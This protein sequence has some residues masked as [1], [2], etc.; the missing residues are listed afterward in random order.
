MGGGKQ[1]RGERADDQMMM[2]TTDR[3]RMSGCRR[4]GAF[5]RWTWVGGCKG[6]GRGRRRV[7][8]GWI[9]R[10]WARRDS[11]TS[12]A[13]LQLLAHLLTYRSGDLF[14]VGEVQL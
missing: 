13:W 5:G 9:N 12:L 6:R 8:C 10:K 2:V 7:V 1:K 11:D 4:C 14:Q 3:T